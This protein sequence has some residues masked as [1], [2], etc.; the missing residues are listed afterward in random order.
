MKIAVASSGLGH[1][2]RGIE[3]WAADLGAALAD[4]REDVTLFKGGGTKQYPYEKVVPCW[5]RGDERTAR[6]LRRLPKRFSWRVGLGSGYEIEQLTFALR[7]IPHLKRDRFDILHVQDPLVAITLQRARRMGLVPTRT[8][9]MHGT[10]EPAQF[11]RRI[12]HVQQITPWHLEQARRAGFAKPAWTAINNFI[13]TDLFKP[14]QCRDLRDELG[15]DQ[16]SPVIL[17]VAAVKRQHKR[18]DHLLGEFSRLIGNDQ[19]PPPILVVA[20]G[21]ESDTD[22]LIAEGTAALGDQ[23]RFLIRFPRQRMPDLYR[24]ADLFVLCSLSEMS[25]LSLVEAGASGLPCLVNQNPVLEWMTGPGGIPIDMTARGALAS[26]IRD[27]LEDGIRRNSLGQLAR[28]HCL[29]LFRR[30]RVVD[31]IL[32]FYHSVLA[33][34]GGMPG[35]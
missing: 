17:T 32:D 3:S 26:S 9:L 16:E 2:T 22:G 10:E 5:R 6:I 21:W 15:I 7:L 25:P 11:L 24:I 34:G 12:D 29:T 35:D 13:D 28:E 4:R 33:D 19:G 27:L 20:G 23:V 14:G 8:I 31:S 18:I 30:D 1:V